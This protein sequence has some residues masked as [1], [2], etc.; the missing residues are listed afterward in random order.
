MIRWPSFWAGMSWSIE[1]NGVGSGRSR[2]G[3]SGVRIGTGVG[4]G[5]GLGLGLG[6]RAP[7]RDLNQVGWL[8]QGRCC[9][10]AI[11]EHD[12]GWH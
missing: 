5:L 12:T 11:M 1:W 8:F 2:A 3:V 6:L 4:V 7:D 9:V 10:L